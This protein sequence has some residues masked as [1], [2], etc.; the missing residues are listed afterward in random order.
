M[1]NRVFAG[2]TYSNNFDSGERFNFWF[3]LWHA[4]ILL[5]R[6]SYQRMMK[7][8]DVDHCG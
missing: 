7:R 5:M 3:D 8:K 2:T 1:V 4:L 6:L